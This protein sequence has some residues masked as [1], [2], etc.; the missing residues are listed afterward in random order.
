MN[1]CGRS[2]WLNIHH[3][4]TNSSWKFLISASKPSRTIESTLPSRR[5]FSVS[6]KHCK[7]KEWDYLYLEAWWRRQLIFLSNTRP[8]IL[9]APTYILL[10]QIVQ[11]SRAIF[12]KICGLSSVQGHWLCLQIWHEATPKFFISCS[13]ISCDQRRATPVSL[14]TTSTLIRKHFREILKNFRYQLISVGT[15]INFLENSHLNLSSPLISHSTH[16][17][18]T[19]TFFWLF[20]KS[21]QKKTHQ[22]HVYLHSSSTFALMFECIWKYKNPLLDYIT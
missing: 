5:W 10:P 1:F 7:K 16:F 15:R 11:L 14:A 6:W 21:I 3:L 4:L 20:L 12:P 18:S 8:T 2:L 19:K 17:L 13:S 22:P 9:S